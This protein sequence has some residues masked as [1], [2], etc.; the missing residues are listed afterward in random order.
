M[1]C[2]VYH[3]SLQQ[4]VR[5]SVCL[6]VPASASTFHHQLPWYFIRWLETPTAC[7]SQI[8]NVIWQISR[9]HRSKNLV[10]RVKFRVFGYFLENAWGNGLKY[11][12][13]LYPDHLI[14]FFISVYWFYLF[15]MHFDS[16]KH[17]KCV[18]SV[19]DRERMTVMAWN[20]LYR[21][22]LTTLRSKCFYLVTFCWYSSFLTL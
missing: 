15:W 17:F 16:M 12:M 6:S 8:S 7:G 5:P 22:I 20:L 9:S 1:V 18:V 14:I 3:F 21:C 10:K 11:P 4:T 19:F 2:S 13:P